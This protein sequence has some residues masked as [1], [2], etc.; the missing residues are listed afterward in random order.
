V[1]VSY[2]QEDKDVAQALARKLNARGISTWLDTEKI[3]G[4]ENWDENL[5]QAID[6][7]RL[8]IVLVSDKTTP[9]A[10][11]M[12][13]EWATIQDSTW[14]RSDLSVCPILL[15]DDVAVP[16]F[17][18]RWQGLRLSRKAEDIDEAVENIV[19]IVQRDPSEQIVEPSE[20][21]VSET[22]SRF[23]EIAQTLQESQKAGRKE[24]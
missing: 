23:S 5:R 14:R 11:K 8:C 21:D 1:F 17:L 7:S 12:S 15:D 9:P 16:R 19:D 24:E 2:A 13:R 10:A 18:R 20:R 4:G 6:T 22:V 3:R